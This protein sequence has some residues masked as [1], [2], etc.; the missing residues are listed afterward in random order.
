MASLVLDHMTTDGIDVL[1]GFVPTQVIR[2]EA[3]LNVEMSTVD[4]SFTKT[5]TFDTV[6]IATGNY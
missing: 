4:G 6:L 5:D 1:S 3:C 2:T